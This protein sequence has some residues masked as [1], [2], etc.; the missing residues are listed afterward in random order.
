MS[1]HTTAE[2]VAEATKVSE[3][4]EA[5]VASA[6]TRL[7]EAATDM[8]LRVISERTT[9]LATAIGAAQ[10]Y[11]TFLTALS[12]TKED[13]SPRF[14]PAEAFAQMCLNEATQGSDDSWSGREN[15][16]KRAAKDG[17]KDALSNIRWMVA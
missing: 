5:A 16:T 3:R 10:G 17:F 13:D 8:D 6:R 12:L 1:T 11:S 15:D 9:A 4:A 14:T 7:V 2:V